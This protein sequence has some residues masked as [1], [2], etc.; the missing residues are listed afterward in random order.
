MEDDDVAICLLRSL[1][2]SYENVV[3]NLEMICA[4][5][6][7]RHVARVLT[8]DYIKRQGEKTASVKTEEAV[9]DFSTERDPPSAHSA[10]KWN[11]RSSTAGPS[12]S[13]RIRCSTRQHQPLTLSEQSSAANQQVRRG[14]RSSGVRGIA[15]S[16]N[17][18]RK[19]CARDV[20]DR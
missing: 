10:K 14:L 18:D 17:F 5:L 7:S 12:R 8:N 1:L 20:G 6:R 9:K 13:K 3:L 11:T 15:E 16:T 19:E 2:N 4:E